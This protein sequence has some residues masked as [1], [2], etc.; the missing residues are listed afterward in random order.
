[1][2]QL[3]WAPLYILNEYVQHIQEKWN[4]PNLP[5]NYHKRNVSLNRWHISIII[6]CFWMS[7]C[8]SVCF[9]YLNLPPTDFYFPTT[10][11]PISKADD[12][13]YDLVSRFTYVRTSVTTTNIVALVFTSFHKTIFFQRCLWTTRRLQECIGCLRMGAAGSASAVFRWAANW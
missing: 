13:I 1:M 5:S 11:A 2:H 4:H 3:R 9:D 7:V 8:V 10:A 12:C 6:W